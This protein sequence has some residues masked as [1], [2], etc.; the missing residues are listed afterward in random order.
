MSH[1]DDLMKTIKAKAF[2]LGIPEYARQADIPE[3]TV[4]RLLKKPPTA[5]ENLKKLEDVARGTPA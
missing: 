1:F 4:R 3:D 2:E 5:I